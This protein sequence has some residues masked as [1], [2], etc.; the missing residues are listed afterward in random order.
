MLGYTRE[1]TFGMHVSR[2]ETKFIGEDLNHLLERN[3]SNGRREQFETLH[4]HKDGATLDV[5]VSTFPLEWDHQTVL[6]CSARDIS[7][8][9]SNEKKIAELLNEQQAILDSHLVGLVRVKNRRIVWTNAA[10]AAMF[11]YSGAELIGQPTRIV[12]PS[13]QAHAAFSEAALPVIQG[14]GIYRTEIEQVRKD[15]SL[16]WYEISCGL[17]YP[18]SEE[19]IGVFID[20]TEKKR[21]RDELEQQRHFLEH[22]VEART[23]D[24]SLAKE[25]A[26]AANRAKTAFLANMS[27]ELRTPLNGIMGMTAVALRRTNDA[28]LT[29]YLTKVLQSSERLRNLINNILDIVWIESERFDLKATD[30]ELDDVLERLIHQQGSIAR[31]KGLVFGI[32]VAAELGRRLF[33]GDA[34]RLGQLL[35]H[36]ANNAVKYTDNGTVN[37]RITVAEETL[38]DVLL[39][40]EVRDTGIGIATEHQERLFRAF[41][42]ADTSMTR[43]YSG[44][45]FHTESKVIGKHSHQLRIP[46]GQNHLANSDTGTRANQGKLRKV[47][48]RSQRE[49]VAAPN[50]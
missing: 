2:W 49:R 40:F 14:G 42:Q 11:G 5:E 24:L 15:S 37:I 25:A 38:T 47:V 32:D 4:R 16:G 7:V 22:E 6:F 41:E 29:E 3:L 48:V 9:K 27:H 43:K 39:R 26:E 8:R 28:R 45:G 44:T 46:L 18:G 36:L 35:A 23:L 19:Q 12:Y 33:N 50:R 30:F 31:H 1:E 10:Y 34:V 17:L 20:S 21:L 13:D